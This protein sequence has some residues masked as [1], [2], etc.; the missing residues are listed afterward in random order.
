MK[1]LTELTARLLEASESMT[2]YLHDHTAELAKGEGP[3]VFSAT[4]A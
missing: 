1:T 4:E 2:G 3:H